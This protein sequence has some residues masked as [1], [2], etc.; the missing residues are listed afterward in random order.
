MLEFVNRTGSD[1]YKWDSEEAKGKLPLWVA[2]M[3]FKAAPAIRYALQRRLD[4]GVFGYNIVPQRYFDAVSNWFS[5]RHGW[6]GI[7]REQLIPTIG[8]VPALSAVLRALSWRER[9]WAEN[10]R[11]KVL[12]LT[13][14]YNCFFSSIRNLDAE[15]VECRLIE[16]NGRYEIDWTDFEKKIEQSDVFIF[17]NPHNPTGRVWTRDEII[18]IQGICEFYGIFVI[19]DEI[20]CEI[21]MPGHEYI[22]YASLMEPDDDYYCVLTSA[23]KAFNL[24]GLQCACIYVP[25]LP[26]YEQVNRAINVHEVCD[27]N[28]FGIEAAIAAYNECEDWIDELNQQIYSNYQLLD[29]FIAKY[30]PQLHLTPLEGTYLAWVNI[31]NTGMRAEQLCRQLSEKE[32]VLFNPS[33]MYGVSGYI[34]INL[35]TSEEILLESLSRLQHFL[36][37]SAVDVQQK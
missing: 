2:D 7:K 25:D 24:A 11:M 12:T 5:R 3:D 23:S 16:I 6:H 20:H 35:A 17:C 33:E 18:R 15:L 10:G 30:L 34:R 27:L 28:P 4:H 29:D 1:C 31:K 37:N 9:P 26:M 21:V 19:S 14:A 22:P 32:N 13:P 8:V 36:L